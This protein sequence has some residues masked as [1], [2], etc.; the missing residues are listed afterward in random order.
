MKISFLLIIVLLRVLTAEPIYTEQPLATTG[1]TS[2]ATNGQ[3]G[4]TY[5]DTRNWVMCKQS[6]GYSGHQSDYEY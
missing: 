5:S 1:R 2:V 3:L 6:L 4:A